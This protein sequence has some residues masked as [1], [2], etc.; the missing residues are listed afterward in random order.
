[1]RLLRPALPVLAGVAASRLLKMMYVDQSKL[2]Q[3]VRD[4]YL[5]PVRIKGSM[6]GLMAMMRDRALDPPIDYQHITMPVLILCG[7]QDEVVPLSAAQRLRERLQ[8]TRLV[9][10]EGAAHGLLEERPDECARA[11][12]DFLREVGAQSPEGAASTSSG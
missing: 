7:A 11:I 4:E 3:E 12:R 10:I 6:D 8:H 2:T 5:R 9:V 1:L